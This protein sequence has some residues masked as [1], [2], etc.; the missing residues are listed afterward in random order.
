MADEAIQVTDP[1]RV[2]V[3]FV[4][5][6]IGIG[7]ANGVVNVAFATALFSVGP[8]GKVI[9]DLVVSSRLRM[10]LWCVQQLHDQLAHILAQNVKTTGGMQ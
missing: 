1:H 10:D 2:G 7:H 6:V 4:N 5:Q 9:P 8:D 3:T